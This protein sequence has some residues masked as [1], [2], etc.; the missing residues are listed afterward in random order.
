MAKLSVKQIGKS[1]TDA[2]LGGAAVYAGALSLDLTAQQISNLIPATTQASIGGTPVIRA[3]SG[4]A[5]I[6]LADLLTPAKYKKYA[7]LAGCGMASEVISGFVGPI[8][9]PKLQSMNLISASDGAR[10]TLA[11][12]VPAASTSTATT[13]TSGYV[14][15]RGYT[16]A[17]RGY[18]SL[19]GYVAG[20][21]LGL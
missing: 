10:Q 9:G 21:P 13:S 1:L 2:A 17:M 14:G 6:V 5:G 4:V 20:N 12:G 3:L 11:Q 8:L 7:Y 19:R 16:G 18:T 15:M